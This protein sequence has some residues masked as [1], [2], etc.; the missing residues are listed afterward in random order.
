MLGAWGLINPPPSVPLYLCAQ[1]WCLVHGTLATLRRNRRFCFFF[2]LWSFGRLDFCAQAAGFVVGTSATLQQNRWFRL[3]LLGVPWAS[4]GRLLGLPLGGLGRPL[5]SLWAL[6]V[7]SWRPWETLGEHFGEPWVPIGLPL[8][9]V[10]SLLLSGSSWLPLVAQMASHR[11]PPHL[12]LKN[13]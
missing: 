8:G 6:F 10:L 5:G 4:P 9:L 11:A 12:A 1:A 2:P 3:F 13:C 7:A